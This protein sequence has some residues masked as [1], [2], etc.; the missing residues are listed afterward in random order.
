MAKS[1]LINCIGATTIDLAKIKGLKINGHF[2]ELMG[3]VR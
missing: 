2:F 3:G 1:E